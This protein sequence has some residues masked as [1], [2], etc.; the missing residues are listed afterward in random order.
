MDGGYPVRLEPLGQSG[1]AAVV[2]AALYFLG[3]IAAIV[4]WILTGFM[5][6]D[7][8]VV[9]CVC[10]L[11]LAW[12]A[13]RCYPCAGLDSSC[14]CL[15]PMTNVFTAQ[16]MLLCEWGGMFGVASHTMWKWVAL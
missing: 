5:V 3:A 9:S 12:A 13:F 14:G 4:S 10:A 16:C 7:F 8:I 2:V 6:Y 1:A 15:C 11:S